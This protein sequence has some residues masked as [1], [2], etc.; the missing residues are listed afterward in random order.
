MV[1]KTASGIKLL[2]L[3]KS[4]PLKVNIGQQL[5]ACNKFARDK[6]M[7]VNSLFSD[8]INMNSIHLFATP[9]FQN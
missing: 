3:G 5:N 4:K 2:Q 8:T 9:F 6:H 7:V 1:N